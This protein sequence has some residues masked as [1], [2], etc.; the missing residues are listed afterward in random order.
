MSPK[1]RK[2]NFFLGGY[3][4]YDEWCKRRV[5]AA[6]KANDP[7]NR[8]DHEITIIERKFLELINAENDVKALLR[9][10]EE[11]FP[12]MTLKESVAEDDPQDDKP[13][14]EIKLSS[15]ATIIN[16]KGYTRKT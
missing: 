6:V 9:E 10:E 16:Y 2:I 7:K 8:L 12:F 5:D 1:D 15:A 3:D 14:K 11:K 13:E 4:E